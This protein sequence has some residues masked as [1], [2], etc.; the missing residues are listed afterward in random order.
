MAGHV[1]WEHDG[2]WF[3]SS[4]LDCDVRELANPVH[5]EC[6]LDGIETRTS[7]TR[8]RGLGAKIPARQAGLVRALRV[9]GGVEGA[10]QTGFLPRESAGV[11]TRL[12]SG[13]EGFDF[14][15][16]R[17]GSER[18]SRDGFQIRRA[19]FDSWQ[20]RPGVSEEP[21]LIN[22]A[23][24]ID[25]RAADDI[26]PWRGYAAGPDKSAQQGSTPWRCTQAKQGKW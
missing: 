12:S 18:R 11:D 8:A 19:R 6:I 17:P 16:R 1:P 23:D 26:A 15:T 21:D 7:P 3:D 4:Q 24:G 9:T 20:A 14:P 25:T 22:L 13:G 2:C 10:E 5:R